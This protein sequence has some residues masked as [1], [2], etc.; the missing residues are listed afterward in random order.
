VRI[1][2]ALGST[3]ALA[4]VVGGGLALHPE[5]LQRGTD[6]PA[7]RPAAVTSASS[8]S[9]PA[10]ATVTSGMNPVTGQNSASQ[11]GASQNGASQNGASQNGVPSYTLDSSVLGVPWVPGP[12]VQLPELVFTPPAPGAAGQVSTR[13]RSEQFGH[14]SQWTAQPQVNG[15]VRRLVKT[16]AANGYVVI[17]AEAG[18]LHL[19][20]GP[21]SDAYYID[22][23]SGE[24]RVYRVDGGP[25]YD[26]SYR[27]VRYDRSP[28]AAETAC[29]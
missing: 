26:V 20:C 29:Q 19:L 11:N 6:T 3:V 7:T 14:T 22:S 1:L 15:P 10:R 12:S 8:A 23:H 18:D 5:L 17:P 21:G 27:F 13:A 25:R 24:W 28:L 4:A 2:P 16:V 9:G